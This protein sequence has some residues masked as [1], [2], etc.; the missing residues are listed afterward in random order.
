MS[1]SPPSQ[2]IRVAIV[3]GS[4]VHPAVVGD[5]SVHVENFGNND[6]WRLF[7]ELQNEGRVEW[8]RFH[9]A[10]NYFRQRRV[11]WNFEGY[12]VIYCQI[13]D[14]DQNPKVLKIARKIV[15]E[16]GLPIINHPARVLSTTREKVASA[17]ASTSDVIAPRTVRLPRPDINMLKR[18]IERGSIDFPLF[19]RP[20]GMHTNR[21]T[22]VCANEGEAKAA[23]ADGAGSMYATE[24]VDFH[25]ADGVFR[26]YRFF[27]IGDSMLFRHVIMSDDWNIHAD[28]IERFMVPNPQFFEEEKQLH[29]MGIDHKIPGANRKLMEI[30]DTFG[31]DY[32]G[33]DCGFMPDGRVVIF[34]VNATMNYFPIGQIDPLECK[35]V[36]LPRGMDAIE[37]LVVQ[38]AAV[39]AEFNSPAGFGRVV[40]SQRSVPQTALDRG[41]QARCNARCAA[42]RQ[43]LSRMNRL[44]PD[45]SGLAQALICPECLDCL[46]LSTRAH[47]DQVILG[48]G[49]LGLS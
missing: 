46:S 8:K 33:I 48:I 16:A 4:D 42:Q 3:Q 13:S 43:P 34:E 44:H 14:F 1:D 18:H 45:I 5:R 27:R 21:G 29:E 7:R 26:K 19:I 10:R 30:A 17:L 31:L 35:K 6:A 36:C 28:D 41:T 37:R 39:P 20:V 9:I 49:L 32:V 23:L 22:P 25:S 2:T 47:F 40:V 12:D 15:N 11:R 24:F 38:K